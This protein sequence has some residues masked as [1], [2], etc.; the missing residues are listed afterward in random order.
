MSCFFSFFFLEM[1]PFARQNPPSLEKPLAVTAS[2]T[3]LPINTVLSRPP[4]L[5]QVAQM[6]GELLNPSTDLEP[7]TS[8][9]ELETLLD[10]TLEAQKLKLMEELNSPV[11]TMDV[12][13]SENLPPSDVNL[14][15]A[16]VENMDWLDLTLSVPAEGI[17]P[18]DMSVP[19]GVFSS[20]FL[21]SHEL[22]LNW[23]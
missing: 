22:Q 21:D 10:S 1:S 17:N 13:F 3:T 19:E 18:L 11:V 20:D 14:T 8:R 5:V 2:V 16:T 9:N 4:P 12:N 7:L 6:P 15:N 23:D